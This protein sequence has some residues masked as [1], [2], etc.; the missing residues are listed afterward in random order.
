MLAVLFRMEIPNI[1]VEQLLGPA[2]AIGIV[3]FTFLLYW[4]LRPQPDPFPYESREALMS[5]SE[6]AF[7][8]VLEEALE[9]EYRIYSKVRLEDVIQVRP[10]TDSRSAFTARNRIKSRHVDFLLCDPESMEI[11]A[12]IELDDRSHERQDRIERDIFVDEALRVS[13]VPCIHFPV[14]RKYSRRE[15]RRGIEEGISKDN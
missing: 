7:F 5:E 3:L 11:I 8:E 2:I 15:L 1:Q 4:L 6:L 10:G 9:D 14:Q 13:G 12:S